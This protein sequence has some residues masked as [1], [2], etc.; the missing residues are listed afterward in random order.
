[1]SSL[2]VIFLFSSRRPHTI[3][4]RDWSSDV[5][6]SDLAVPFPSLLPLIRGDGNDRNRRGFPDREPDASPSG[7]VD[8]LSGF[9]RLNHRQKGRSE[10]RRVGKE[11]ETRVQRHAREETQQ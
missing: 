3:S 8:G 7:N 11:C 6:S 1:S 10:E 5:C 9:L 4:K 2:V